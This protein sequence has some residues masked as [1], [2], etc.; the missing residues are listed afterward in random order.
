MCSYL[1]VMIERHRSITL[2]GLRVA[3][4]AV[5]FSVTRAVGNRAILHLKFAEG[6]VARP[7]QADLHMYPVRRWACQNEK[8]LPAQGWETF[9]FGNNTIRFPEE[10]FGKMAELRRTEILEAGTVLPISVHDLYSY[11]DWICDD[12]RGEVL[13]SQTAFVVILRLAG[14]EIMA[15]YSNGSQRQDI[16]FL[17]LVKKTKLQFQKFLPYSLSWACAKVCGLWDLEVPRNL[18]EVCSSGLTCKMVQAAHG[19]DDDVVIAPIFR[20]RGSD[21]SWAGDVM[22]ANHLRHALNRV[23]SCLCILMER[24][25]GNTTWN[26]SARRQQARRCNLISAATKVFRE[27]K[28]DWA[29][30]MAPKS[31]TVPL[32]LSDFYSDA[33]AGIGKCN[34]KHDPA[35]EAVRKRQLA[36]RWRSA[37]RDQDGYRY[38][39]LADSRTDPSRACNRR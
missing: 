6:V 21:S 12:G 35:F 7:R 26:R 34:S 17:C 4:R 33:I 10:V 19:S 22:E 2:L 36:M 27:A 20:S 16:L 9:S 18:Q 25:E 3:S 38:L 1:L 15:T 5:L 14:V 31:T 37:D 28:C 13:G 8:L 23:K 30:R 11:Q 32:L 29:W 39:A 24:L